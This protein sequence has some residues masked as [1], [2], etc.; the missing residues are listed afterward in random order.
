MNTRN[1]LCILTSSAIVSGLFGSCSFMEAR[2]KTDITNA[3]TAYITA[4]QDADYDTS[5]SL[6]IDEEDFFAGNAMDE[7]DA[8]LISAIWNSTQFDIDD[9][10][11]DE[12]SST[13][14]VTFSFPDLESISNEGYSF[15]EFVE[16]IPQIEGTNEQSLEFELTKEDEVWLIES[17]STE[18]LYNLLTGL[19]EGL[20]FGRLTE[21]NAVAAVETFISLMAE[22][23]ITSATAM[24]KDTDNTFYGYVQTASSV[25]GVVVG[26]SDA[27]TNY[28][29]RVDYEA[30]ATEV[31]D[32][33][34]IVTVTG[35][36]PDLQ[37][38]VDS[39]LEN[40]DVMV[41]VYADYIE[42]YLNGNVNVISIAGSLL[43]ELAPAINEAPMIPLESQFKVTEEEDGELYLE[44]LTGPDL[45]VDVNSLMN[46][47][48]YIASAVGQLFREGRITLEQLT[49]F[50]AS[51]LTGN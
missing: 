15:D 45:Q 11:L 40:E 26:V 28:F 3:L 44:P 36:A 23:D 31:T 12:T 22:G 21:E 4:V 46:R 48:D 6:V 47:T 18:E 37:N 2:D 9:V 16:A 25:S 10:S 29:G 7:D 14:T 34:I 27:F 33:Y 5:K 8:T 1:I 41:P 39:V 17:D 50:D 13:A 32:E 35:T 42:G 24:L 20:E 51:Q 49:S 30:Q 43:P 38:A 19:I